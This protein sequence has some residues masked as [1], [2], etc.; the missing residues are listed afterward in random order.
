MK[1]YETYGI[2]V[3]GKYWTEIIFFKTKKLGTLTFTM[4]LKINSTVDKR[5]SLFVVDIYSQEEKHAN[6]ERRNETILKLR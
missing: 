1:S 5:C 6:A 3:G 4:K 2:D